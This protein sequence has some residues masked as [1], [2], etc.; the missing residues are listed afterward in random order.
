[1]EIFTPQTSR[2][3]LRS[4]VERNN[5]SPKIHPFS[6]SPS[7][8]A[9][10]RQHFEKRV[11]Y[12]LAFLFLLTGLL[13]LTGASSLTEAFVNWGYPA[14]FVYFAGGVETLG[15]ILLLRYKSSFY[16]AVILG[17]TMF[18]AF[19]THLVF[20]ELLMIGVPLGLLV[21]LAN[22]ALQRSEPVIQLMEHLLSADYWGS[23]L[24]TPRAQH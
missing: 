8:S 21:L 6:N 24:D 12:S 3:E 18:A 1:M 23:K 22:V 4:H 16:G 10:Q 9:V 13:K 20:G 5:A 11:I 17:L 7:R 15:A 19:L 2:S 14:W